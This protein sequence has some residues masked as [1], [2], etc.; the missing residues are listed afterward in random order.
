M[1]NKI[2]TVSVFILAPIELVWKKWINP[3]DI[4]KWNHTSDD[5]H[6]T[7]AENDLKVGGKF[8]YRMEAKDKSMGFDFEGEYTKITEHNTIEY[9]IVDGRNVS[10]TFLIKE[11]GIEISESFE[12]ESTNSID[13]Q[14]AGWQAILDNFKKYAEQL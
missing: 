1:E 3:A 4:V 11:S 5:W 2:I 9:K 6:T 7:R 8:L 13:L 12:A 14:R 10:I